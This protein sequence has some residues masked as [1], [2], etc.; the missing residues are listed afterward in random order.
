MFLN[1]FYDNIF[2]YR[3][4]IIIIYIIVIFFAL[5]RYS[6]YVSLIKD[7]N[8]VACPEKAIRKSKTSSMTGWKGTDR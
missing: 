6:D 2:F 5:S 1:C 4:K 3:R 8:I 7:E